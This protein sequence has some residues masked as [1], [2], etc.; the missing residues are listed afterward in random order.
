MG[1]SING[2]HKYSTVRVPSL[3]SYIEPCVIVSTR[4]SKLRDNQS[5]ELEQKS[6]PSSEDSSEGAE[7]SLQL[8]DTEHLYI[9]VLLPFTLLLLCYHLEGV[10][11]MIM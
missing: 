6:K 3:F 2:C 8:Q 4:F 11:L 9:N 5:L 7:S 1:E 10:L